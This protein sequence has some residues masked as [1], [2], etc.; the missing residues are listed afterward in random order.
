MKKYISPKVEFVNLRVEER[1]AGSI[2]N[3]A[4]TKDVEYTLPSGQVL[5]F[6]AGH[7]PV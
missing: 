7:S 5:K 1:M 6:Y 3:G 4:C 2:C